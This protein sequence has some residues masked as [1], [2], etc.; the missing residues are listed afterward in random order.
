VSPL[1]GLLPLGLVV[2]LLNLNGFAFAEDSERL[3]CSR[4]TGC[5]HGEN[6]QAADSVAARPLQNRLH[7][8]AALLC[9]KE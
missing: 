2:F 1:K 9:L 5:C 6:E 7:H 4:S 8:Y 3:G